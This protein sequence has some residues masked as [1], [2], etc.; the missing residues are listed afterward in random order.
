MEQ[1]EP[2][3]PNAELEPPAEIDQQPDQPEEVT[4]D[5]ITASEVRTTTA[6][7]PVRRKPSRSRNHC[8]AIH[9]ETKN[10]RKPAIESLIEEELEMLTSSTTLTVLAF[11]QSK[12]EQHAMAA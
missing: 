9:R 3:Q 8:M 1:P 10:T 12:R 6:P 4:D 2:E 11:A 7:E 5:D